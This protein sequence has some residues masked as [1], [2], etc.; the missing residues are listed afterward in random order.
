[1]TKSGGSH[2]AKTKLVESGGALTNLVDGPQG[3]C[4]TGHL[5]SSKNVLRVQF[6][7]NLRDE[8]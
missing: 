3:V 1:M 2:D 5:K 4:E 7:T 8:A 6:H